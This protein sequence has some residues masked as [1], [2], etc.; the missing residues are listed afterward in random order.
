M[1][2]KIWK[3]VAI[4]GWS[5]LLISIIIIII[6]ENNNTIVINY[7]HE[8]ECTK[9]IQY[10]FYE[11]RYKKKIL[12]KKIF[13]NDFLQSNCFIRD[14]YGYIINNFIVRK[15]SFRRNNILVTVNPK[16][17]CICIHMRMLLFITHPNI[18]TLTFDLNGKFL[19]S[20]WNDKAGLKTRWQQGR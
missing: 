4:L 6:Y 7:Y 12:T 20:N 16:V 15:I 13:D 3:W 11:E 17:K 14:M 1:N 9:L 19:Q 10:N 5:L 8:N 18:M 2:L